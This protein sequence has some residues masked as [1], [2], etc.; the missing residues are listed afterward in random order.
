MNQEHQ[1]SQAG[2]VHRENQVSMG[3]LESREYR[4]ATEARVSSDPMVQ[5]V[6]GARQDHVVLAET[7]DP[8]VCLE[9][10]E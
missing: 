9:M 3:C 8:R 6:A 5:P 10:A 7:M 2:Q 4:V 1:D